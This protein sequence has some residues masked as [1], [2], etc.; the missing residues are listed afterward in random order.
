MSAGVVGHDDDDGKGV[1]T[2]ARADYLLQ[3][4]RETIRRKDVIRRSQLWSILAPVVYGDWDECETSSY[5][6]AI[7][8]FG[9]QLYRVPGRIRGDAAAAGEF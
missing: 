8:K 6:V 3:R 7:P 1:R 4:V 5:N 2:S 9:Y